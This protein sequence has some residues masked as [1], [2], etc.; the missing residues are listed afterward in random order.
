LPVNAPTTTA[1]K[2]APYNAAVQQLLNRCGRCAAP[3]ACHAVELPDGVTLRCELIS[4]IRTP[5]REDI[6]QIKLTAAVRAVANLDPPLYE[7]RRVGP[8]CAADRSFWPFPINGP[9]SPSSGVMPGSWI[10]FP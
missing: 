8:S 4:T 7:I 3:P 2:G 9:A 1:K 6:V 10:R 5:G